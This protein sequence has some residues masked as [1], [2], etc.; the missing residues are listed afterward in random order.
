MY[1]HVDVIP[2]IKIAVAPSSVAISAIVNHQSSRHPVSEMYAR[3]V[4]QDGQR[5]INACAD[6]RTCAHVSILNIEDIGQ[7]FGFG[8]LLL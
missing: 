6:S 8:E 3:Y 5:Q 7:Y 4:L 2:K 1:F